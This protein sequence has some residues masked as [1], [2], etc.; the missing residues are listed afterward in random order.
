MEWHRSARERARGTAP[1]SRPVLGDGLPGETD[2]RREAREILS[3]LAAGIGTL[4]ERTSDPS[5][6]RDLLV[7]FERLNTDLLDRLATLHARIVEGEAGREE[8]TETTRE[9]E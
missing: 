3:D 8:P 7:E 6:L 4:R 9:G 2:D 1:R 5:E